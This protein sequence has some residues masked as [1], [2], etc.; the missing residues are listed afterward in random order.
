MVREPGR[1]AA[2]TPGE[3]IIDDRIARLKMQ[4]AAGM[5]TA[6]HL[7]VDQVKGTLLRSQPRNRLIRVII[8]MIKGWMI[9]VMQYCDGFMVV[10]RGMAKR[11]G[12]R[13]LLRRQQQQRQHPPQSDGTQGLAKQ[14]PTNHV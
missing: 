6:Q 2:G 14:R 4:P 7:A 9:M 3:G 12:Q 5:Q 11:M 13:P 1:R 8:R 10:P